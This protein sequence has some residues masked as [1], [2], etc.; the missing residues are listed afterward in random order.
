LEV[1]RDGDVVPDGALA[2][3]QGRLAFAFLVCNRGRVV[4]R[5]E[6]ADLLWED[7]LPESWAASLSAVVSRVRRQLTEA[8]L[9]GAAAL[10][11][12]GE[13]YRLSLPD[14]VVVD[15]EVA[16][17]EIARA[18]QA[19][20]VGDSARALDAAANAARI[21]AKGF[22]TDTCA[23][24]DGQRSVAA[25]VCV[26]AALVTAEAHLAAGAA[27]RAV[28][29]AR[30]T[31]ALDE[32]REA[33]YRVLMRALDAAGER[34]EALR[35]W[36]RC[37][38][39]LADELGVDPSPDTEA[40]YLA[41]LQATPAPSP[42]PTGVVTFLLT[43]I[44]ESSAMWEHEPTAMAAAL[45]RHDELVGEV[46][47]AAGG[48]LL[49]SKLEGDATVSV[50]ARATAGAYAAI[51]LRDAIAAEAWPEGARPAVRM[52][53]HTGEAFERSGDYFGPALNRAARVRGLAGAGQILLT[54]ATSELVQDHL[55]DD[56]ALV[57]LGHHELRGLSRGENLY[58]IV[59]A[60][61]AP[62]AEVAPLTQPALPTALATAGPFVGRGDELAGLWNSW[63][64]ITD[65]G[66]AHA[67]LVAGEPG[68]GKSR[69]AAECARLAHAD[70]GLVVYGR[71]DEELG[72]ALQPFV[73]AIRGLTPALGRDRLRRVRGISE[74]GRLVPEIREQVPE[75][76]GAS[77]ADPD[78]ERQALFDAITE[79]LVVASREAPLLIVL[80]DLHWAGKTTLS[81]L[82]HL[83]RNAGDARL[84][85]VGTYRDTEL[86][87]T[88]PLA[89]T[90]ADLRR[91]RVADRVTLGGL[92]AAEVA[93]YLAAVGNHDTALSRELS[94]VTSGN[95][96]FLIEALR[97]VEESGGVWEPGSL[98]E[99]VREATGRRLS[100]L[101]DAANDALSVAAVAGTT[102]EL[103]L[104]EQVRGTE[105]VDEISEACRAGLVIEDPIAPATFRFAHA[106]VRQVLLAELVTLKRLRLHQAIAEL[107]EAGAPD[108]SRLADLAYHWFECAPAGNGSKAVDA[109]RRA[110]DHAM[111]RLAYEEAGDLY[112][113]A[114]DAAEAGDELA[115]LHL[116]HCDAVLTAGD[117]PAAR[118]A[119]E[120][121]GAAV[122][123]DARLAAWHATYAGQ[124]AVL[125]EP[126]ALPRIVAS[127]GDA[128]RTLRDAGDTNGEAKAHYVHALALERLGQIGAAERALVAAIDAARTAGDQKLADAILAETPPVVLWGPIPVTRASGRCLDV[129]RVLRITSGAPAVE[130][131]A[132]RCQAVLEA[133]RGR[134]DAARRMI[135]SAH[136]KV[137]EV[138]LVHRRLETE[139]S[140]GLIEL[141]GGDPSE[142]ERYLRGAYRELRDRGLDGEAAL[143]AALL[144][145]ALLQLD[146]DDEAEVVAKEAENLAGADLKAAIIWRDVRASAAL[147]R[148]D[149]ALA[150]ELADRAVE[151]ASS[152]D[153]LLLVADARQTL[154]SV[155]RAEGAV[156][157]AA[158]QDRLAVEA[159][160]AKGATV[161]AER[162]GI[163]SRETEAPTRAMGAA[164][165][166]WANA[167][168]R[169]MDQFVDAWAAGDLVTAESF[170]QAD[171]DESMRWTFALGTTF[172]IT[173]LA[174]RGE[175]LAL[176]QVTQAGGDGDD[177]GPFEATFL[178]LVEIDVAGQPSRPVVFE[179]SDLDAARAELDARFIAQDPL[180]ARLLI[181]TFINGRDWAGLG[182]TWH[183]EI[184]FVDHRPLAMGSANGRDDVM[185]L[186][187]SFVEVAPDVRLVIDHVRYNRAADGAF[188]AISAT[189]GS[190]TADGGPFET[191]A[192]IV[193]RANGDSTVTNF[194]LFALT[195]LA[196]AQARYDE[197]R[198][199][200]EFSS[201]EARWG[202]AVWRLT[203]EFALACAGDDWDAVA[204]W[205]PATIEDRS[206]GA[207]L[208]MDRP[209][210]LESMRWSFDLG[211]PQQFTLLA[212]R[213]ENLA[214]TRVT[215]SGD[216][217]SD[218]GAFELCFL[219]VQEVDA[220]G[221]IT[222][223]MFASDA[224]DEAMAYLDERFVAQDPRHAAA[225]LYDP[226]N[227]R[228]WEDL[229][230][231][232]SPDI[233]FSDH[234]AVVSTSTQGP[235]GFLAFASAALGDDARMTLD[236]IRLTVP[237]KGPMAGI[238]AM[239]LVGMSEGGPFET[240]GLVAARTDADTLLTDIEA[241]DLDQYD[242]AWAKY[243][244]FV[245]SPHE[246]NERWSNAA[247]R[248][249]E[250]F[251]AAWADR[252]WDR[253][254]TRMT[255]RVDDRSSGAR[256][257]LDAASI[258]RSLRGIFDTGSEWRVELIA[259]RGDK[260][261]LHRST[262][263][264]RS[265]VDAGP[266]E[267]SMLM[268]DDCSG[269]E[270]E[271][272][273][274]IFDADA[275]D[276]AVA[277]LDARYGETLLF[278]PSQI[279][280]P[281][282]ERN[283]SALLD[284]VPSG[285]EIR[286]HRPLGFGVL[287]RDEWIA[288]SRR[289]T[290]LVPDVRIR[291]LHVREGAQA[292]LTVSCMF[293]TQDSGYFE[294][295]SVS[296]NQIGA[297]GTPRG[298]D[299]FGED[300]ADEAFA[301]F[302][303]VATT[304]WE[305]AASRNTAAMIDAVLARD[306]DRV[307]ALAGESYGIDDRR[308]F[309][310]VVMPGDGLA[311]L[312]GTD[313]IEITTDLLATRGDRLALSTLR[314]VTA[315]ED[316]ESA[317]VTCLLVAEVDA[318]GRRLAEVLFD[319]HDLEAARV[320]LDEKFVAQDPFNAVCLTFTDALDRRDWEGAGTRLAPHIRVV[321]HSPFRLRE[322]VGSGAALKELKA[323]NDISP[324]A[325]HI[326]DHVVYEL[327]PPRGG[328]SLMAL[329]HVGTH[330][331]GHFER[332]VLVVAKGDVGDRVELV[333]YFGGDDV[334]AARSRYDEL[335]AQLK[336]P[337][338][339]AGR[340][341]D[342]LVAAVH[343][344]DW[345]GVRAV[346]APDCRFSD[347]RAFVRPT[348][349]VT[350]EDLIPLFAAI[351]EAEL[352]GEI[353]ATRG[354]SLAIGQITVRVRS[355]AGVG[356]AEIVVLNVSEF[357]EDGRLTT[358]IS[359]EPED[360][361]AAFD[362][363]DARYVAQGGANYAPF[364]QRYARRDWH[365]IRSLFVDD[366]VVT[367][368]RPSGWGRI[369]VDR[370]VDTLRAHVDLSPDARLELRE[371]ID[372]APGV[373]F[374]I[375]ANI[376]T[377]DGGAYE[378]PHLMVVSAGRDGLILST[379]LF[380]LDDLVSARARFEELAAR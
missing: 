19:G 193:V 326:L 131:V 345:D 82:R 88:H 322:V 241:F 54:Q 27:A 74:L 177:G 325:R 312:V 48:T 17:T 309:H 124:L 23:W 268:L 242:A 331:G 262:T 40:V 105:L 327:V 152:T 1:V 145:R 73:E 58:A 95:P 83:L 135:A 334:A 205:A 155:L 363:L 237:A 5:A 15:W 102:F 370:Y 118:A 329:R 79:L 136:R 189:H 372:R 75:A 165:D 222:G 201:P 307:A 351:P 39:L 259:T 29:A 100:H 207:R 26:R 229:V 164:E 353:L 6:L 261:A 35:V 286:D 72:A 356:P 36:E 263:Y 369:D 244:E 202:N 183:A 320:H 42:L 56:V 199:A 4:S 337:D 347:R 367:D 378:L 22:L 175:H 191:S 91:D 379:D 221:N 328:A 174:T 314:V 107:I 65:R 226:V 142:A 200:D 310:R 63:S 156:S 219:T 147:R 323:S 376:G 228:D 284:S 336:A 303:R 275:L 159:A 186:T 240:H 203:Q 360:L 341:F 252:D 283:W 160:T 14:D 280:R 126:D 210:V 188:A 108:E 98:P 300:Q 172:R 16:Q 119:I 324:D 37:R 137:E 167:A 204:Q 257:T 148:G 13:G 130:S 149:I 94:E 195:D 294:T 271:F 213:G 365:T 181:S 117:V 111:E 269:S 281:F 61:D 182:S 349:G 297:D 114:I 62:L 171:V 127:I 103:A 64:A 335:V 377:I 298:I 96:F 99:G 366:A 248:R 116:A 371:E 157:S 180:H 163:A 76:A 46:M 344:R 78:T 295:R 86:A 9:D 224:F 38:V 274:V 346:F 311:A 32:V 123:D 358:V 10:S 89:A 67:V 317:D 225:L 25:D 43:D 338:H 110:A 93:A 51:A 352:E 178:V 291:V 80:D 18:E 166:G 150:R 143:A 31:V 184:A 290:E 146:R 106:L 238:V 287:S 3:K 266:F 50:F 374:T 77:S 55:S 49:K 87:R 59:A 288:L 211:V 138:G 333:E 316:G 227:R 141:L 90:I 359:F 215:Q 305:N 214:L 161:L 319:E 47:R 169:V 187:K 66:G 364:R 301:L 272:E 265:D 81:L 139:V 115:A 348:E 218:E 230:S 362:E 233:A 350:A 246:T 318:N 20:R 234:R 113:M 273:T 289:T 231:R 340:V 122:T 133:L 28:A 282:N 8:G 85:V 33:G 104:I 270:D 277:E 223:V 251:A 216:N 245:A 256:I 2:G 250:E 112:R 208:R 70:G 249:V 308:G 264:G 206:S 236:H 134:S 30:E 144:G 21:A 173:P 302:E 235:A 162:A 258:E 354:P 368:H 24:A 140:A 170:V 304:A 285:F 69:L 198:R 220:A 109:C 179:H 12:A 52:A 373:T 243:Q 361:D 299:S 296:V 121:F 129:V 151:L 292:T 232:L 44:V 255:P 168:S 196:N 276:E 176:M 254:R 154:A 84:F 7:R 355:E 321:D 267:L 97:H 192:C 253:V 380:E 332:A 306:W 101:S 120:S 185:A 217:G 41:I 278:Q 247:W 339:V 357:D 132:L 197:F 71:C 315:F 212:T 57:D 68:V 342:R 313:R 279:E 260:L 92:D 209:A 343:A 194:E 53:L 330:E 34:A 293:G 125:A 11:N 128:A 158:E 239:R 190:G 60:A 153:A 375:A 45:E